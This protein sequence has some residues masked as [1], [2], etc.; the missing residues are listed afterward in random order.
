MIGFAAVPIFLGVAV[1]TAGGQPSSA[2]KILIIMCDQLNART[3]GCYGGPVPTPN[4][5][6]LA[7]QGVLFTNATCPTPFCSPTRASIITG[8]YPHAHGITYNV[9]RRD[10]PMVTAPPTQQG[11]TVSDVTTEK[12][13]HEAGYATH[14]YGKW[15]LLDDDLPYYTDMFTEHGAYAQE[16]AD[17]FA[18]VRQRPPSQWMD[19]YRWALPVT[20]TPAFQQAI[21]AAQQRWGKPR[22]LE[23]VAKMGRL[24][25]PLEQNFD[26][27]TADKTI[28]RIRA[29]ANRPSM[30]TCSFNAPH[31]PNVAPAPYYE[32]FDLAAIQLPSNHGVRETRF[33]KSWS[34]QMVSGFG[35]SGLREFLRIYY[36]SVKM[37]DDQVGRIM[38]ALK[39][40]KELDQTVIVFTADHGDMAGGH[41]M[42]WKSNGSFYDEIVVV[43]LLIRYPRLFSPQRCKLAVDL[44]DLMPTLLEIAG[45]PIPKQA[46]GQSLVPYLTGRRDSAQARRYS[47][48]ERVRANRQNTRRVEP[49][50]PGSFMVRGQGW[51]YVRYWDGTEYLYHLATDPGETRNLASQADSAP[52]KRQMGGALQEWQQ[53]TGWIE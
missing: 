33:E 30:I 24:E 4:L 53:R 15:H 17:T 19:W 49:G 8:M 38:E 7:R 16:M 42:A 3:L 14:H 48:A 44:T 23:F 5:D 27:R 21:Q 12:I 1:A 10:Y 45:Q 46:Q 43:P 13:L 39:Q 52:V 6:R 25:L 32:M 37:I 9:M 29:L 41:G 20:R 36:A 47:F 50:T 31:D 11:I 40:T 22:H 18:A 28:A 51:K 35:S 34:R 26:V 2:P